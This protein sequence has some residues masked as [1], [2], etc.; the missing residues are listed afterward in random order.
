MQYSTY[1]QKKM[2]IPDSVHS[3]PFSYTRAKGKYSDRTSANMPIENLEEEGLPKNPNLQLAQWKFLLTTDRYKDDK[4]I[5]QKLL[6]FLKENGSLISVDLLVFRALSILPC[7]CV[8]G[9]KYLSEVSIFYFC[10]QISTEAVY[11]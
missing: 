8:G 4:E 10:H 3:G 1:T 6:D 9:A 7:H 2:K 11:F 5:K